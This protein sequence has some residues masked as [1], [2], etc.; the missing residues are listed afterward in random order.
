MQNNLLTKQNKK[1]QK[2]IYYNFLL[3]NLNIYF[4]IQ[5]II[6]FVDYYRNKI[7][8]G[9]PKIYLLNN[10]WNRSKDERYSKLHKNIMTYIKILIK[11]LI[12]L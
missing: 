11:L 10:G 1:Y 4:I 6:I 5:Y 3:Y 9:I 7:R 12:E 2:S 8:N